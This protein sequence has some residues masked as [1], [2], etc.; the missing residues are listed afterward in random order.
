M[1]NHKPQERRGERRTKEVRRFL[2]IVR[3]KARDKRIT[4]AKRASENLVP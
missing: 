3:K 1:K 4:H 2:K